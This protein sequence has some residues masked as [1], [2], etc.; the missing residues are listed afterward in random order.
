VEGG[1]P[2]EYPNNTGLT[3]PDVR[4]MQ[5]Y[6]YSLLYILMYKVKHQ[7]NI[8]QYTSIHHSNI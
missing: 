8:S 6:T 3:R 5:V 1:G 7:V 2:S 4:Q